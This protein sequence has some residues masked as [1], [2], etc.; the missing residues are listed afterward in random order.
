MNSISMAFLLTTLAGLSTILGT[1]PIFLNL[2]NKDI[3]IASSLSFAS[4]VMICV[5][6]TDLIPE[7]IEM[8]TNYFNGFLVVFLSFIFILLGI[9]ISSLIDKY[10]PSE[11]ENK[12]NKGL[13][14]IGIIKTL[15]SFQFL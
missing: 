10:L 7:S 15:K 9:I 1:I 8:L 11:Y 14:K 13:Y 5:S 3:I 2:K 12:D 4:G 6:I